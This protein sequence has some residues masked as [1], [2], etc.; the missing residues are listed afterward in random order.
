MSFVPWR[1]K[2]KNKIR[3]KLVLLYEE[4]KVTLSIVFIIICLL[5]L[6]EKLYECQTIKK[7]K[8]YGKFVITAVEESLY[9]Q[10]IFLFLI[11]ILE[12]VFVK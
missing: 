11:F 4:A 10:A 1:G 7:C 9:V 5:K 8:S 6:E 3:S 12:R 2:N